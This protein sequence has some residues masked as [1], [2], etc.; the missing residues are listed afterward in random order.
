LA[1]LT[2]ALKSEDALSRYWGQDLLAKI[3]AE[4]GQYRADSYV[5]KLDRLLKPHQSKDARTM[6]VGITEANIYGGD[7]NFVFSVSTTNPQSHVGLMS[8]YMMQGNPACPYSYSS[9]V[10]RLDQ[11][12][13]NLSDEVKQVLNKLRDKKL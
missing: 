9:G 13:L 11:K 5:E 10:E 6:Y 7:N 2:N 3:S 1:S 12:T 4:P 8:Y